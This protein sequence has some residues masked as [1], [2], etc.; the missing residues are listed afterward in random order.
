M[1]TLPI[2]GQHA[3]TGLVAVEPASG[4]TGAAGQPMTLFRRQGAQTLARAATFSPYLFAESEAL[5]QSAPVRPV[6]ERLAGAGNLK[7]LATFASWPDWERAKAWLVQATGRTA[8][9]PAAPFL[10]LND[11]VQQFLLIT[12]RTL[13]KGMAFEQ[14]RRLQVDLETHTAP[15]FE[16]CNAERE[17]DRIIL[18]TLSD[19]SGWEAVLE[20]RRDEKHLL[21]QFVRLVRERDPDVIE[22]HNLFKFDLPYLMARA[23]RRQ[24]PLALGR[25]GSLPRAHPSR[26]MAG[27]RVV[28]FPKF[29][30]YGRHVVDTLFL[31]Q[32]YD[33]A[34]RSL[35]GF[36]LKEAAAHFHLSAPDRTLIEGAEISREYDRNPERVVRYARDDIRE[37]RALSDLLSPSYFVQAQML[38]YPYHQVPLRGQAVKIDALL[39]REYLR[40]RRALPRPAPP[41]PF[42]GGY[43]EVFAAGVFRNVHHVDVRSLY[44]SIMLLRRL[45]PRSDDLGVFLQLLEHLR[46]YRLEA[47]NQAQ[48]AGSPAERAHAEA[49]QTAFK[50]LIN[51]FYGYLGFAPARFNDFDAAEQVTTEG[52]T[53]VKRMVAWLQEHGARPIEVDTDGVYFVPPPWTSAGAREKFR[54]DL[55]TILPAGIEIEFDGAYASMFSYKMKNY[56]LLDA[57]G[58]I[59]IRGAALKSR[60]LEPYLRALIREMLRLKL[61]FREDELPALKARYEKALRDGALP[62]KQLAKT[63]TLKEDPQNYARKVAGKSRSRNAAYELAL[64]SGRNYQAGDQVAYYITGAKRTVSAHAAAKSISDWNPAQRDENIPFYLARLNT[65]YE[66][67]ISGKGVGPGKENEDESALPLA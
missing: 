26:F 51:S 37:T 58:E 24:V 9:D 57:A 23:R 60:G 61:E 13:F 14:L 25:D 16:F 3:E 21:E 36:G 18:I 52:R 44:P 15:G 8:T 39:L 35:T 28:S 66:R 45:G 62:I 59:I 54:R 5:F 30:I 49:L 31:L 19:E 42:E 29:E 65:V 33:I 48:T 50:V 56:A 55:Q 40:Q 12:G 41:R 46:A 20:D 22:G 34:H 6:C 38:P 1:T 17:S 7:V 10:A 53:I 63:E 2:F 67:F 32:A 43:T 64:R 27:E 11:P 47:K 4:R